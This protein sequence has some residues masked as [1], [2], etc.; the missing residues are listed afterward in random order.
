MAKTRNDWSDWF[1]YDETSPSC[2]RWKVDIYSSSGRRTKAQA[3]RCAG[4]L[5]KT[6]GYFQL[7]LQQLTYQVH[8]VIYE[9]EI[10]EIPH[11]SNIDHEDRD[12]S[13]NKLNNIRATKL[14]NR[15]LPLQERNS[16]GTCGVTW[17]QNGWQAQWRELDGKHCSKYFSAIKY[18]SSKAKELAIAVREAAITDL[19]IR[20]AGYTEIHGR[21]I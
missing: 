8:R 2:L 5:D 10:G 18:G 15:N 19:N 14:N 1:Y 12:K 7:R 17:Q 6:S 20:G 3:G 4:G 11:G 16:S 13:N 21:S 9:M